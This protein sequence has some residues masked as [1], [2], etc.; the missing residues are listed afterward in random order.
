[1]LCAL[2]SEIETSNLIANY[3]L[4]SKFIIQRRRSR[5]KSHEATLLGQTLSVSF[6]VIVT[7]LALFSE[8]L[9]AQLLDD[10]A[11]SGKL[12]EIG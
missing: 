4:G 12:L 2:E 8:E 6:T 10:K 9:F 1:M 7:V 5:N 3:A 11:D